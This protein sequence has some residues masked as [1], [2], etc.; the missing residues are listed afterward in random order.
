MRWPSAGPCALPWRG[1]RVYGKNHSRMPLRLSHLLSCPPP[2]SPPSSLSL[3]PTLRSAFMWLCSA[4]VTSII[5]SAVTPLKVRPTYLLRQRQRTHSQGNHATGL[6]AVRLCVVSAPVPVPVHGSVYTRGSLVPEGD[7]VG[8]DGRVG[9]ERVRAT[10]APRVVWS[11]AT[12]ARSAPAR[13]K[14]AAADAHATRSWAALWL[15][16]PAAVVLTPWVPAGGKCVDHHSRSC[17]ARSLSIRILEAS[18]VRCRTI[19]NCCTRALCL[20]A[21][22][23]LSPS[24]SLCVSLC[25]SLWVSLCHCVCA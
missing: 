2:R 8:L 3:L 22:L 23:S 13:G 17:Y 11:L 18:Q 21:S 20:S 12:S 10:L 16:H 5:W 1:R 19:H 15:C 25:V 4:L 24:V 14:Q 9:L 7:W 6:A